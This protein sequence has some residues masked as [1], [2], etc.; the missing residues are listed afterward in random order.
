VTAAPFRSEVPIVE[1]AE[2]MINI[3]AAHE[4]IH[5]GFPLPGSWLI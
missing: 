5:Y 3:R 4:P 1:E 2:I